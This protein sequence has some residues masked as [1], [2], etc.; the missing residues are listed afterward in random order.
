[1]ITVALSQD[2]VQQFVVELWVQQLVV[3]LI[4]KALFQDGVQQFFVVLTFAKLLKALYFTTRKSRRR[5]RTRRTRT[6]SRWRSSTSLWTSSSTPAGV[7]C[8]S[9]LH[10]TVV[11]VLGSGSARSLTANKNSTPERWRDA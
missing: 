11:G 3:E 5:S 6:W 2:K 9:V 4:I 8:A 1:M 7:P 10:T